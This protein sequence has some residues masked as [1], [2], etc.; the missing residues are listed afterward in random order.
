MPQVD[1]LSVAVTADT[2]AFTQGITE[3]DRLAKSFGKSM[4]GS[5]AS[6]I[7]KGKSLTDTLTTLSAKIATMALKSVFSS[8]FSGLGS[9]FS[10]GGG[11]GEEDMGGDT[12]DI[13]P[14]AKGGVVSSPTYFPMTGGAG[15]MGEA[16]SEAIMPLTRGSDGRLGVAAAGGGSSQNI[17]FNVQA[18]DAASFQRS[19]GEI[20]AMLARAVGRGHRNL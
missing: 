15:V 7:V 13:T 19:E 16:G 5:L 8:G 3:C 20:N 9:M 2:A 18:S 6:S 11:G 14:F 12:G 4:A 17:T 10:G 1:T